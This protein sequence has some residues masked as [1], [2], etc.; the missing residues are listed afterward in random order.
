[1]YA[2]WCVYIVC[3]CGICGEWCGICV[4]TAEGD[5]CM[6]TGVRCVVCVVCVYEKDLHCFYVDCLANETHMR[7]HNTYSPQA[8]KH[9]K[10]SEPF[11]R[12]E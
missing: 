7:T 4:C 2:V 3:M 1:M 5:W 10:G 11:Q 8:I 12:T 6:W 9:G